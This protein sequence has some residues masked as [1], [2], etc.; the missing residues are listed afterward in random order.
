MKEQQEKAI[1]Y[2]KTLDVNACITG[3]ALLDYFEGADIDLFAFDEAAFTKLLYTFKFN[4]MFTVLDKLEEWKIEDW[5]DSSYKQVIKKNGMVTVKFYWNLC[6]PINLVYKQKSNNIFSV[7]SSFD[8][9]IICIAYDLKT[10]QTLDL[11]NG[12]QETKIAD[13]NRWNPNYYTKSPWSVGRLLRQLE[14]C[15]KY[16][17]RGYVTDSVVL[18]YRSILTE[19]LEYENIFN[20]SKVDEKIDSV[21][22]S[23]IIII[24]IIDSWL[25]THQISDEELLL[26]KET[27][28]TI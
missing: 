18:K 23:S 22:E 24:K 8:M 6:I 17:L 25:D 21:K 14:R 3:S 10:K 28:K 2:L 12:S 19:M 27:I 20:S 5:C 15:F 4:P 26:L 11:T 13:W 9:S 16:F 7:L 1:E